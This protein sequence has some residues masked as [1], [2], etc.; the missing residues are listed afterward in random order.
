MPWNWLP[1]AISAGTRLVGGFLQNRSQRRQQK[2][3]IGA[4]RQFAQSGIQWRVED[5]KK[6]GIHP[7]YALGAQTHSFAPSSVGGSSLAEQLSHAGQDISRA[8]H[9]NSPQSQRERIYQ[10]QVRELSV[11]RLGLENDLLASQI[12]KTRS[13]VGPPLPTLSSGAGVRPRL[14]LIGQF[15]ATPSPDEVPH[16]VAEDEYGEA[17]NLWSA[18]RMLRDMGYDVYDRVRTGMRDGSSYDP[19]VH[20]PLY[21]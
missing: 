11:A 19:T 15:G 21:P 8:I 17:V 16:R 2:A 6:A 7:L 18:I 4:Q 20:G 12:A 5:A 13:Q 9:A 1:A 14:G 3:N 10:D